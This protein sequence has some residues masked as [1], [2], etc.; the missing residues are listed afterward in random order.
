MVAFRRAW[1]E[2]VWMCEELWILAKHPS[3]KVSHSELK[4]HWFKLW[5]RK[6]IIWKLDVWDQYYL[7]SLIERQLK[8]MLD[9][10]EGPN[11]MSCGAKRNAKRIRWTLRLLEMHQEETYTMRNYLEMEAK[12]DQPNDMKFEPSKKDEYG[13]DVLFKMINTR[14][15]EQNAEYRSGSRKATEMDEKVWR[16]FIKNLG[17]MRH[18]WD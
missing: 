5:R 14:T 4:Y 11:P 10:W 15:E 13:I 9:F 7:L 16:L 6:G 3:R 17:H 8:D 12:H 2:I 18:W 1:Y